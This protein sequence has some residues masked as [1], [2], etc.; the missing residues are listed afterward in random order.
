[1]D[2][3][4]P[5]SGGAFLGDRIRMQDLTLDSGVFIRSMATR[6]SLGGIAESTIDAIK[7]LDA[8]GIDIIIV[9]SVGAGQLDV[10]ISDVAHT[11]IVVLAPG[12][13]D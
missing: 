13:G 6:G 3:T 9:E 7:V 10:R 2:P 4:S 8:S 12:F 11:T 5:F 1:M